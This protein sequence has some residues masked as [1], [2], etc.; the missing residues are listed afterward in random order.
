MSGLPVPVWF[1]AKAILSRIIAGER[2]EDIAK[3]FNVTKEV[4]SY[5]LRTKATDDW[6]EAQVIRDIRR[7]EEAEDAIDSATDMLQLNK[8]MAKLKSAQWSLERLCSRIFGDIK[9]PTNERPVIIDIK[10]YRPGDEQ[11]KVIEHE[12]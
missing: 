12:P 4:L 10:L 6:K 1:D 11:Q 7:K 5:H 8:A 9:E 2:T 3:G